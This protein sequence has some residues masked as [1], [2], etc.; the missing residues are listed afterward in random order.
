MPFPKEAIKEILEG[1]DHSKDDL[2]TDDGSPLVSEIQRLAD[3]KTIT[4]A[5]I[6]EA[7][8]G[9]TRV[10]GSP[11]ESDKAPDPEV[12][13]KDGFDAS[14]EPEVN[15]PGEPL[16]EEEVRVILVRRIRD[17]EQ[18]LA[19]ART[20]TSDARQAEHAAERRLNR[21]IF[22]HQRKFPPITA[23]ANIKAHLEAQGRLAQERAGILNDG[24]SQVDVSMER[25]NRR[26]WTRPTRPVNN[27][28]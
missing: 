25:S 18:G 21:A 16:T 2:W 27:V 24:R 23:A 1:L 11:T 7:L 8:P 4:R 19:D 9:F 26:G 20:A 17:A 13:A 14:L 6:N 22:D 12:E 15:G 28:A 3:D 5:Q 10:V